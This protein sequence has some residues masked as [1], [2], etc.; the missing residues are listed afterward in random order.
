MRVPVKDYGAWFTILVSVVMAVLRSWP[1]TVRTSAWSSRIEPWHTG[2][3]R[4]AAA[5]WQAES[6]LARSKVGG[7][8]RVG[9]MIEQLF[10]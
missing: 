7:R 10:V 3:S 5:R 4:P 1:S 9:F 2:S 6:L 8:R